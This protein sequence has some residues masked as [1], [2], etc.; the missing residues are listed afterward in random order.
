MIADAG[1][2]FIW[3]SGLLLVGIFGFIVMAFVLVGKFVGLVFRVLGGGGPKRTS[4]RQRPPSRLSRGVV[5]PHTR[6]AHANMKGA[7]FCAR[8]GRPLRSA[9]D[10]DLY[11]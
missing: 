5:C 7:R 6:C 10:A 11:G 3:V 4:Y 1:I 2:T 9:Y 8:C